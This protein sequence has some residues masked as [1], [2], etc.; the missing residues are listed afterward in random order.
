M[1]DIRKRVTS[2]T[3]TLL[4]ANATALVPDQTVITQWNIDVMVDAAKAKKNPG[5]AKA[6]E[7]AL[8][9]MGGSVSVGSMTDKLIVKN[10]SY[11]IVSQATATPIIASFLP[12]ATATRTSRGRS[13]NS[14]LAST[15]FTEERT[16]GQ[17]RRVVLDYS[18]KSTQYFKAGQPTKR[19]TLPYLT[20]DSASLPYLFFK[21]PTPGALVTVAAT[22]GLSTRIFRLHPSP[23]SVIINGKPI[24]AIKLTHAPA[25]PSEAGLSMWIRK[26]DGFPL[27]VRLDL[28]ARYGAILDQQLKALPAGF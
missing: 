4:C 24:P 6:A 18:K 7:G 27:R 8:S 14:Y 1:I 2:V 28:N 19:E 20:A 9:L 17:L 21:R 15:E 22:D 13:D 5:V 23:D 16:K 26:T 25:S 10:G 3:L 11:A 12:N